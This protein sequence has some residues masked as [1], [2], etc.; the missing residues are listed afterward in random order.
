MTSTKPEEEPAAK[1]APAA[2][3]AA[4]VPAHD[5][6]ACQQQV[7][8]ATNRMWEMVAGSD[9]M[10][11]H[12]VSQ[13]NRTEG[14]LAS[15]QASHQTG[16]AHPM[17]RLS[18]VQDTWGNSLVRKKTFGLDKG[19]PKSK[20]IKTAQQPS[21]PTESEAVPFSKPKPA[22]KKLG[23]R[24]QVK[25]AAAAIE[26]ENSSGAA[27]MASADQPTADQSSKA[28]QSSKATK[29][30]RL[31]K[32]GKCHHCLRPTLKKGC[33]WI[34]EQKALLAGQST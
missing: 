18:R 9:E 29:A 23:P 31:P 14:V 11:Q 30:P 4:A 12:L 15:I 25:A 5:S 13:L 33:I 27:N 3:A 34:K 21:Q 20:R 7:Q 26:K 19:Y 24:Q 17:A 28:G 10:Q 32:C 2:A 1:A 8:A 22:R 16:T 6:A